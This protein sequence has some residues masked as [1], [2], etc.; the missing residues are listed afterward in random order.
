MLLNLL[1]NA[2]KYAADGK[3]LTV[4]LK[5]QDNEL[6]LMVMDRGPGIPAKHREKIFEKFYRIDD[7]LTARQPGSG[8]GLSIARIIMREMKGDIFY[9]ARVG[10]GSCFS[11]VIPRNAN[12]S[13]G[14]SRKGAAT[15]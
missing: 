4:D 3:E 5:A 11:V 13:Q 14:T 8:L 15:A 2:I 1:D 12:G 10:G 9:E 7:S 6:K